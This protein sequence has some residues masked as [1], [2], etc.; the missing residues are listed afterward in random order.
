MSDT[1]RRGVLAAAGGA[2]AALAG[3]A[4]RG[5]PSTCT[6]ASFP[7]GTA[8]RSE[9][10]E[11][12]QFGAELSRKGLDVDSTVSVTGEDAGVF[13]FHRED[14]HRRDITTVAL[15]F[16]PYRR[17]VARGS[18]LTFTALESNDDRHGVGHIPRE[19]ADR[20]AAGS[21]TREDYVKRVVD[22]YG[23]R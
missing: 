17:M 19:W 18:L 4:T 1:T 7:A 15:T 14:R 21:L 6:P 10:P 5:D 13:Y 20:R 22:S 23:S 16:V 12:C 11:P 9:P 3:C 8:T 2:V